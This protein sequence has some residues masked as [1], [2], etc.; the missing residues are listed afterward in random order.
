MDSCFPTSHEKTLEGPNRETLRDRNSSLWSKE[1]AVSTSGSSKWKGLEQSFNIFRV[2]ICSGKK[3]QPVLIIP[4]PT[5]QASPHPPP[6]WDYCL[7]HSNV[8]LLC[9]SILLIS[10]FI[11]KILITKAPLCLRMISQHFYKTKLQPQVR[12]IN[13]QDILQKVA[14]SSGQNGL[15]IE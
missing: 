3:S 1:S 15:L 14:F 4:H 13:F 7:S 9:C 11:R 5:P 12:L 6:P 8:S 2:E 10:F